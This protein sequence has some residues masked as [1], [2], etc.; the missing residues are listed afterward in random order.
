MVGLD[1]LYLFRFLVYRNVTI[2]DWEFS[3]INNHL[4]FHVSMLIIIKK[5][6]SIIR[7]IKYHNEKVPQSFKI[8][9]CLELNIPNIMFLS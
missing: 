8:F 2:R 1:R 5:S 3:S 7:M 6:S 9:I 4:F